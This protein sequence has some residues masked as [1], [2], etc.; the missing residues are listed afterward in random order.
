MQLLFS[1][2]YRQVRVGS[3]LL[4]PHGNVFLAINYNRSTLPGRSHC[5]LE[6]TSSCQSTLIS[7]YMTPGGYKSGF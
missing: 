1:S 7:Q 3:S 2:S 5:F 6:V 4:H